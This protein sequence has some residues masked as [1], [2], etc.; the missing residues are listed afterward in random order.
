[1]QVQSP[2]QAVDD[3]ESESSEFCLQAP[4]VGTPWC[5]PRSAGDGDGGAQTEG[6]TQAPV[7]VH[8]PFERPCGRR[9]RPAGPSG[10]DLDLAQDRRPRRP[11]GPAASLRSLDG[12]RA[13]TEP[14]PRRAAGG[15]GAGPGASRGRAE[16]GV[17]AED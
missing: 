10:R 13:P 2:V 15:V 12:R 7:T 6:S 4:T 14:G 8:G 16:R 5:R 17:L 1:M 11:R 3:E 9:R